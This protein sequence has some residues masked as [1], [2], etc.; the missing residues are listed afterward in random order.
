VLDGKKV[1]LLTL[2]KMNLCDL[3]TSVSTVPVLSG[4]LKQAENFGN[5]VKKCPYKP[6][7]YYIKQYGT[8][9]NSE[10]MFL[11]GGLYFSNVQVLDENVK[12]F[13]VLKLEIHFEF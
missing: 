12:R 13:N 5:L 6:G 10:I 9:S 8:Q 2:P 1:K 3:T 7:V 4:F 11:P